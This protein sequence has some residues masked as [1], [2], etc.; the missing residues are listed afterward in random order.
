ML[1]FRSEEHIERWRSAWGQPRGETLSPE[2]AWG[3]AKAWYSEDRRELDWRRKT[4]EEAQAIF[5]SLGLR[6][7]FWR[8]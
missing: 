5:G 3:L 7:D 4:A 1:L 6:S 8:L 2:Q